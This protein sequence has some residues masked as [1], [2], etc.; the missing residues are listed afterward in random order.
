MVIFMKRYFYINKDFC[1]R[2]YGDLIKLT[3][4]FNDFDMFFKLDSFPN[5]VL[6]CQETSKTYVI[7]NGEEY[8]LTRQF[9]SIDRNTEFIILSER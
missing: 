4:D 5:F 3:Q 1:V 6:G 9:I 7:L 8:V 2:T